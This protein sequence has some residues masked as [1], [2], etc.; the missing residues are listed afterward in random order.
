MQM[1]I[2]RLWRAL[3]VLLLSTPA[4]AQNERRPVEDVRPLLF[5]ALRSPTGTASGVASG[6]L[7]KM[8]ATRFSTSSPLLIDVST[9]RRYSQAGCARL[10]VK[11]AQSGVSDSKNSPVSPKVI[12]VQL[13]YCLDGRPPKTVELTK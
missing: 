10:N 13:N 1:N 5:D 7:A 12:A 6:A 11:F 2:P 4:L 9:L 8:V 3:L